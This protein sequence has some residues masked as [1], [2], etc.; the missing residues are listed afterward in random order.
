MQNLFFSLS[1]FI[2][3]TKFSIS[4][5]NDFIERRNYEWV[6][7]LKS[8]TH[9]GFFIYLRDFFGEFLFFSSLFCFYLLCVF[10]LRFF[11]GFEIDFGFDYCQVLV[12]SILFLDRKL[13]KFCLISLSLAFSFVRILRLQQDFVLTWIWLVHLYKFLVD[14]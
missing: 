14:I 6:R 8:L 9:W 1:T 2:N 5:I 12:M 7:L 4:K 11:C 3:V 10:V 13:G